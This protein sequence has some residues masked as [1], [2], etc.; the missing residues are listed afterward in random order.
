MRIDST[1]TSRPDFDDLQQ[2]REKTRARWIFA[3]L[4]LLVLIWFLFQLFG[5][6]GGIVVSKETTFITEPLGEDGLPDYGAFLLNRASEGV[7][8]Q[9]NA[10]VLTWQAM[11]PGEL[12]Q[13]HWLPMADALGLKTIPSAEDS[14]VRPYDQSVR[15]EIARWLTEQFSKT[16]EGEAAERLLGVDWQARLEQETADNLIGAAME[17]PWTSDQIPA[18]ARWVEDN[19]RP[20]ELLVEASARPHFYS[21]SP[22]LIDNSDK[23]LIEMLLPAVQGM[24]SGVRALKARAMWHLGEGRTAEAWQD[25]LACHRLARLVPRGNTLVEQLIAI[26]IDGVACR[27]TITLLHHGNLSV[28]QSRAILADLL[29]L[30]RVSSMQQSLD[31]GERLFFLD[32]VLRMAQGK[33][34]G[35]DMSGPGAGPL[36]A[37]S[38]VAIDWNHILREGNRWYD[39]FSKALELPRDERKKEFQQIDNDLQ[40]IAAA[41]KRPGMVIG[42]IFSRQRRSQ[43]IS[44]I[45]A[46]LFL[47]AL[48][49]AA[50]AEDRSIAILDMTRV[51]AALAVYRAEHGEYP[52]QLAVL[53]PEI[54]PEVPLDL[55]SGAPLIYERKADGGYLLYSVF[56][57]GTD[58]RGTSQADQIV[59]GEWVDAPP[60]GL[61]RDTSDL[62]IRVPEPAFKLPD[63]PTIEEWP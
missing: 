61:R 32:A 55:Y 56:E 23:S 24:R 31:T 14:L 10:A 53:T 27:G 28:E 35:Q 19:R 49:S 47:P 41:A 38:F 11:W 63:P 3:G 46:S 13:E 57:N 17:R 48:E 54:L 26:A 5:P 40:Q 21:P 58:E 33:M 8:P 15:K 25:L 62:V 52:E 45:L 34:Q 50:Y 30:P 16:L 44:N 22:T 2:A 37:V 9:N 12:E 43:M 4:V 39:R 6:Q 60:E 42:G 29:A 20:L 59:D 7:T 18:L 36:Q 1:A 51:A